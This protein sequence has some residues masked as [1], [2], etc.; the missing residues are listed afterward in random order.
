VCGMWYGW[1]VFDLSSK[2]G[3]RVVYIT[4]YEVCQCFPF[5]RCKVYLWMSVD[6]LFS[7][8]CSRS[9]DI[10]CLDVFV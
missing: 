8:L 6:P 1:E 10:L 9:L 4:I 5:G 2:V 7:S 3:Q